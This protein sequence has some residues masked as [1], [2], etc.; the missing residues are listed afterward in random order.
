MKESKTINSL[1]SMKLNLYVDKRHF[2]PIPKAKDYSISYGLSAAPVPEQ[3]TN[4]STRLTVSE[5]NQPIPTK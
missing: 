3:S 2:M 4:S 5:N 1:N